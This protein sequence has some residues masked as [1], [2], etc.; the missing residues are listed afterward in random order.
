MAGYFWAGL[1][2][3]LAIWVVAEALMQLR[4]PVSRKL[5]ERVFAVVIADGPVEDLAYYLQRIRADL[6]GCGFLGCD[7]LL[8]EDSLDPE[9]RR[10]A[11]RLE[12]VRLCTQKE[13]AAM[14]LDV[15]DFGR[16]EV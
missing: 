11:S 3:G 14:P 15:Y 13:L 1:L 2:I 8:A 9:S 16:R 12:G 5:H 6:S 7:I 10:I 4:R